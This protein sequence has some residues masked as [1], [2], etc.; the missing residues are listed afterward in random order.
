MPELLAGVNLPAPMMPASP[1]PHPTND[2]PG[3]VKLPGI[4]TGIPNS[5]DRHQLTP[6]PQRQNPPNSPPPPHRQPRSHKIR[7]PPHNKPHTT[8]PESPQ[9]PHPYQW[10]AWA[11]QIAR[12]TYQ[13]PQFK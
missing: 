8:T 6:P 4:P 3:P 2:L 9:F 13:H 5:N 7:G 11:H 12:N 1:F 10:P